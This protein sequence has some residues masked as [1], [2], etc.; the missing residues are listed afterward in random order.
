MVFA[1]IKSLVPTRLKAYVK[2]GSERQ[3]FANL[4]SS[5]EKEKDN[6]DL[7]L[8]TAIHT[9]L[10]DHLISLA[11]KQMMEEVNSG[12]KVYEI[13]SE[14]YQFYKKRL[15]KAIRPSTR[16]F[17][18]G[19]GWMG[20]LWL[21]EERLLQDIVYSFHRQKIVI[22]PQT[23]YYDE[24]IKPYQELI[25]RG[26]KIYEKC[27]DIKL[28]VRDQQSYDFAFSNLNIKKVEL[29]PDIALYYTA[30][31]LAKKKNKILGI[32]MR[33]DREKSS[34]AGFVN[35]ICELLKKRG[36]QV[37]EIS[38][39]ND[40]RVASNQ[41]EKVCNRKLKDFSECSIII[42]DRLHGMIFSYISGT[43]CIAFDNK[44]KKVS[45]VY[46]Q[47]LVD[48]K[49]IFPA[50]TQPDLTKIMNFIESD[51][52]D[53]LEKKNLSDVFN[54]IIEEVQYGRN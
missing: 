1:F 31:N 7:L 35:Q 32:C 11:E 41:R 18:N 38:T 47:W 4:V 26:N 10:G 44:T 33:N 50:F 52:V 16:V 53:R 43:P 49:S 34:D 9:N 42:S 37:R 15:E 29:V 6:Y 12:R 22:F 5:L 19:G 46:N 27:N 3:E 45:G 48:C 54:P 51:A 21:N 23:I 40:T 13:P 28:F 8:G 17:I 2:M 14:V 24:T 39:M 25:D 30:N 20:N 36:F